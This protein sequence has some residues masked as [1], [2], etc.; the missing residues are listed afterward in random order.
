MT[1]CLKI[2]IK[3]KSRTNNKLH[4][5]QDNSHSPEILWFTKGGFFFFLGLLGCIFHCSKYLNFLLFSLL[6]VFLFTCPSLIT[7]SFFI[8]QKGKVQIPDRVWMQDDCKSH[9]GNRHNPHPRETHI[10][11]PVGKGFA[12]ACLVPM[13]RPCYPLSLRGRW[14]WRGKPPAKNGGSEKSKDYGLQMIVE[15]PQLQTVDV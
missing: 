5:C 9:G 2:I 6:S 13:P 15:I 4:A 7:P 8:K 14:T 11:S 10:P 3:A 1:L 12:T